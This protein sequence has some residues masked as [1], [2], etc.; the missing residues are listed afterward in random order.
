V[1][2]GFSLIFSFLAGIPA[3]AL[4]YLGLL[5]IRRSRGRI[6]GAGMGDGWMVLGFVGSSAVTLLYFGI[7]AMDVQENTRKSRCAYNLQQIGLAMHQ[8]PEAITNLFPPAAIT[9]RTHP[10]LL[11]WRVAILPYTWS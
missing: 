7:V 1:L 11:S 5:E 10:P 3:I 6:R 4:G 8:L 2:G 9:D